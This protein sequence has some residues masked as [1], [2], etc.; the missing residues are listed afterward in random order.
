[1]EVYTIEVVFHCRTISMYVY[2]YILLGKVRLLNEAAIELL[3]KIL[4]D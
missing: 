4:G 1:M 2:P 3:S